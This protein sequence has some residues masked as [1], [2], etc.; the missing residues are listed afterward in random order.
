MAEQH[1][2]LGYWAVRGVAQVSRHL[3]AYTA[4][5]FENVLYVAR[6]KWFEEDKNKLGFD[7]PNLP[8]LIDGDFKLTESSA[9]NHYIINRSGK[10]ELLGKD[11][12]D[13]AEVNK[14]LSVFN[15]ASKD[16]RALTWNKDYETVKGA[17]LE[18]VK[19]KLDGLQHYLGQKDWF[20]GYLTYVDFV[21]AEG[22]YTFEAI[23]PNEYKKY[24][25]LGRIRR[26][27]N[28]L[29]QIKAY[30]AKEDS[31]KGPFL[32]PGMAA[33]TIELKEEVEEPKHKDVV[34]GYW[35]IRGLCQ[36]ARLLLGYSGVDFEDHL[37]TSREAWFEQDKTS[38]NLEFANIP[39][40][41][42]PEVRLTESAAI[43]KYICDKYSPELLGKGA[44]DIAVVD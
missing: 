15:D 43:Y 6:E 13:R 8:Y 23:Y 16:I 7:F 3:L 10:T 4:T 21:I 29:P 27:F 2:K 38:L 37:Y 42:T 44:K 35:G 25:F 17:V 39:Y 5:P 14:L 19:G 31:F 1:V 28:H 33:I 36:V 30:Y 24:S 20:L 41:I 26:H 22:S 12:H 18:K 11:A 9:I 34:L 32:P 40:L